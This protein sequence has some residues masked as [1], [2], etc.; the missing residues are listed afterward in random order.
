MCKNIYLLFLTILWFCSCHSVRS[1]K[2]K[3]SPFF[4][5]VIRVA[6]EKYDS[7]NKLGAFD[8]IRNKYA[9]LPNLSIEDKM[10]YYGYINTIVMKDIN[11]YDKSIDIA[12]TML[13]ILKDAGR[14]KYEIIREVQA[15]NIKADALMAKGMYN[16][17]YENYFQAKILAK[18]NADSCSFS[19]YSY[20]LGIVLYRQQK[21]PEAADLFKESYSEATY[22]GDDFTYFYLRQELLD[23]IGLC[24]SKAHRYDS[25][26]VYYKKALKYIKDNFNRFPNKTSM[27]Y[28]TAEAVVNGNLADVYIA[29]GNYNAAKT[30]LYNSVAINLQKGYA[31]GDAQVSQVKLAEIY[32]AM[33][34]TLAL[35]LVLQDI[36]AELDTM[37]NKTVELQWNRLMWQYYTGQG[38]STRA[39]RYVINNLELKDKMLTANKSLMTS[40][41]TGRLKSLER[42]HHIE[43]L[44]KENQH[45][46]I[47]FI[48]AVV[49][50]AMAVVIV[51]M[52]L[53]N[54]ARS[55]KN[56][57]VLTELNNKISEQ[58]A[59]L[60]N[61]LR[62]LEA[63]DMDK[64][65]ILRSVAH[66]VMSPI[67]SISALTD[68]LIYENTIVEPEHKEMLGLIQEACHNSLSLSKDILEAADS[69][70]TD[71]LIKEEYNINK[72][73]HS[74][75]ELLAP[76]AAK[77]NQR[78]VL[79]PATEQVTAI[80]NKEKMW[81]VVNNL[82]VNA[83]KFSFADSEIVVGL[84]Q[85]GDT[86]TISIKDS[87]VGIPDK[88]KS[89]IFD[90]F[91]ESKVYGTS[92][93]R[94]HGLGLSISLQV[95][96]VHGGDIKF[97]S[98]VGLGT[99]FYVTFPAGGAG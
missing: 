76:M 57:V 89:K 39:C 49:V 33:K 25:A 99:I 55:A 36:K 43:L 88:N 61:A 1:G 75:V 44:E 31:N 94:P 45:R 68:L 82:I 54:S 72:L 19:R 53:R 50:V 9:A 59:K 84:E 6:E 67:A 13:L 80:I 60:E 92:G 8:F 62:E 65:R 15:Y 52:A 20:S 30:L 91:T 27:P 35:R 26:L 85:K 81:R 2:P 63:R 51:L 86:V 18:D 7:G 95:V 5:S 37:P 78:I 70:G 17:A 29:Q 97:D 64:S 56:V 24:Y 14:S 11:D 4:D 96:K 77:K 69:I 87:G 47:Y 32:Q 74:C 46:D 16:E 22:C 79:L 3:G 71:T 28:E 21:Y 41:I 48:I 42:Q 98:E 34:D 23:N 90:M 58:K 73:L 93:E 83:I 10:N 38:D 40:D 12:D 66:D